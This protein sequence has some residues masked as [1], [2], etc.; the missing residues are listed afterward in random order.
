M[1]AMTAGIEEIKIAGY[2]GRYM[3]LGHGQPLLLLASQLVRIQPYRPLFLRLAEL[4]RVTVLE[5]PGSGGASRLHHGWNCEDY[6][7]WLEQFLEQEG[8]SPLLVAHS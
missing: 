4:F 7:I 6:A 1:L 5:L 2:T 3:Q 8:Q